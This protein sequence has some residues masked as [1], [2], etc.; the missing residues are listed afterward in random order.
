MSVEDFAKCLS[1]EINARVDDLLLLAEDEWHKL[2]EWWSGLSDEEKKLLEAMAAA[3]LTK[4]VE[5]IGA[6]LALAAVAIAALA[7]ILAAVG[8]YVLITAAIACSDLLDA[9]AF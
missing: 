9:P 1:F 3:D 8:L 2:L 5:S 4:F 7:T 6:V